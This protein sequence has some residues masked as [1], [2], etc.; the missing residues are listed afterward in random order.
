MRQIP[1]ER[2]Q[3]LYKRM[4]N[5]PIITGTGLFILFYIMMAFKDF[6]YVSIGIPCFLLGCLFTFKCCIMFFHDGYIIHE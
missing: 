2:F 5:L 4:V 1:K 3:M 6:K